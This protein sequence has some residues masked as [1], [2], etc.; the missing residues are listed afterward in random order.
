M[1]KKN[2]KVSD[3]Y[4][5]ATREQ[6]NKRKEEGKYT[7]YKVKTLLPRGFHP[8][9]SVKSTWWTR[10]M[11]GVGYRGKE[12]SLVHFKLTPLLCTP[13]RVRCDLTF[14]STQVLLEAL[15]EDTVFVSGTALNLNIP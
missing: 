10:G 8:D 11:Y 7:V 3:S 5:P 1:Q 4:A 13:F 9:A 6:R 15:F 14:V 12:D 2:A